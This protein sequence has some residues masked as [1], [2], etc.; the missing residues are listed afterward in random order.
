MPFS[1]YV[2][3][4][5]RLVAAAG[6]VAEKARERMSSELK[7][8]GSI[9]TNADREVEEFFR[10]ELTMVVPGASFWGEEFGYEAPTAEGY[11]LID[12]IDG[13]SNFRYGIPLW[14][15]TVGFMRAGVLEAGC[16]FLP[17][18]GWMFV[19]ERS[20]G[21]TWNGEPIPPIPAGEIRP[22]HL[23]GH[24]DSKTCGGNWPGKMRHIGSFVAEAALVARQNLRGM[25]SA[26]AKLYDVAAG[27]LI[28]R[29]VGAQ[30]LELSGREWRESEWQRP[31]PID[32]FAIVP[33]DSN[34]PFGRI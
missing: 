9:V 4:I 5:E 20:R 32:A 14:G 13:T 21:A 34:F 7:P 12:P 19:G 31:T 6:Q 26:R 1:P 17:D 11:W 18:L 2:V 15:I 22:D 23:M 33:A 27:V 10:R 29:E 30:V 24:G 28:C 8:D 16:I 25:I 3:E